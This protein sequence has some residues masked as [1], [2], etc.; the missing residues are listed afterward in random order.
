MIT[1][2]TLTIPIF[3]VRLTIVIFDRWEEAEKYSSDGIPC[4]GFTEAS[5]AYNNI[6]V[7]IDSH[8]EYTIIHECEHIKNFVWMHIGYRPQSDNDEVDAYLLKYIY[9]R[10]IEVFR[11]HVNSIN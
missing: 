6:V 2:K 7:A 9:K 5:P 3:E 4:K 10:V 8:Y 11:K 1:K